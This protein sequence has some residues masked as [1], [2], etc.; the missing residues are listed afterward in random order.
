[1]NHR[2]SI[3]QRQ[4]QT[5]GGTTMLRRDLLLGGAI[6]GAGLMSRHGLAQAGDKVIPWADQP[7]TVPPALGNVVKGGTPWEDLGSWITPNDKFFSIAH[8]DRPAI[9]ASTWRLDVGGEV[10]ARRA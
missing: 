4:N 3:A 8:Y 5:R 10:T 6:A 1:M 9:D 2:L 7:A